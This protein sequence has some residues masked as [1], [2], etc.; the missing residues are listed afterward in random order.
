MLVSRLALRGSIN[1]WSHWREPT[2]RRPHEAG[3]VLSHGAKEDGPNDVVASPDRGPKM[4]DD[5][6]EVRHD[7]NSI[8]GWRTAGRVDIWVRHDFAQPPGAQRA[9]MLG[10][11][12]LK[13]YRGSRNDCGCPGSPRK[14]CHVSR[15][16]AAAA[17]SRIAAAGGYVPT[18]S[19]AV[20]ATTIIGVPESL[21]WHA[22][23]CG[24]DY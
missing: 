13:Q 1:A 7:A 16:R 2:A 11:P 6:S 5:A 14:V 18:P 19:E 22:R 8:I 24:A 20:D 3:A 15:L 23:A 12:R 10:R 17:G 9:A 21:V 4:L